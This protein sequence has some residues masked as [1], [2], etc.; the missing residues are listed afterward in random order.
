MMKSLAILGG[1]ALTLSTSLTAIAAPYELGFE[2]R[3]SYLPNNVV[4]LTFDDG[5]DW[6][7]TAKVLDT[8]KQKNVKSS[9][10]I[11]SENWSSLS[12]DQPMRDLVKRM[13]DEGHELA[14]HTAHHLHLNGISAAQVESEIVDV[15]RNVN[16]IFGNTSHRLTMLRA[17]HGVP[18]Q[19]NDANNPSPA[20]RLVSPIVARHAVHIG[21]NIDSNDWVCPVGD[22]NCVYNNVM[23]E[24]KTPGQG[25]YGIILMHSVHSQTAD[26]LPRL[27]DAIRARGFQIWTA[28]DAVR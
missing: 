19:D 22:S 8:L 12:Q 13:V 7:N 23:N 9:F 21:W 2:D 20:Y 11:N 10:F 24:L 15:E 27:I 14:N 3:P 25:N 1:L 18:Y 6:V 17:P 26:A 5:P 16:N 28:E 4:V